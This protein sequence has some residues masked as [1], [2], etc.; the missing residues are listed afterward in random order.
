MKRWFIFLL[1]T[2]LAFS[3][4]AQIKVNKAN[5]DNKIYTAVEIEPEPIGGIQRFYEVV[6]GKIRIPKDCDST[7]IFK[8]I[9]LRFVV[10]K[11]GTLTNFEFLKN[12][13]PPVQKEILRVMK[14][15]PKWSAGKQNGKPVRVQF[16][17]P[18]QFE[19]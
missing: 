8:K 6:L 5:D 10:E 19:P 14:L 15:T 18:I 13:V 4:K 1:F 17:I 9:I 11:N 12:T 2:C 16:T 3:L 7:E